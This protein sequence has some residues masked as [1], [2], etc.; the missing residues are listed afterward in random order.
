M[1]DHLHEQLTNLAWTLKSQL[2]TAADMLDRQA[3]L[4][5]TL[6]RETLSTTTWLPEAARPPPPPP[7]PTG[8]T[9][10]PSGSGAV[11]EGQQR[12]QR[13]R[14][15]RRARKAADGGRKE[16]VV[17]AGSP[18][19][20]VARSLALDLERRGFIVFVAVSTVEDEQVVINEG[21]G[22]LR[23]LNIDIL[24]PDSSQSAIEKLQT[25]L[26]TPV[27]SFPG[28]HPH[29]LHFAGL[30]L[31]PT[32]SYPTGPLET[33]PLEH[34]SDTLNL[35]L[36][37]PILTAKLLLRPIRETGARIILCTP[38]IIRPLAPPFHAPECAA[39]AALHSIA[40]A[41]RRELAPS[42]VA[43][44]LMKLGTFDTAAATP[45]A[46]AG[47]GV[48]LLNAARADILGWAPGAR[49]AYARGYAAMRAGGTAVRGS[50][51]RELHLAV[52]EALTCAV[53]RKVVYVGEGSVVYEVL[54][55]WA[56]EWLVGWWLGGGG[57]GGGG[58]EEG[59]WW[60]VG[61]GNGNGSGSGSAGGSASASEGEWERV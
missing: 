12:K 24:D 43:V 55:R 35:K 18:H 45:G 3:D 26:T 22:D 19:D 50:P 4:A 47:K 53:P 25:Y 46:G 34:W 36:L 42:A 11:G 52:A 33:L 57:G 54:G 27:P 49:A 58:R 15:G 39:V 29:R 31:L 41:L 13:R 9:R 16:V 23:P 48:Q 10:P 30:I 20:P 44:C 1:A 38:N 21:R 14:A 51:L 56:P 6:I 60:G 37:S 8:T 32:A 61:N 28:A 7:P 5:A 17:L 59:G 40:A 2:F